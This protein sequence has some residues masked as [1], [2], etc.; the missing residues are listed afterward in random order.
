MY[1]LDGPITSHE[2]HSRCLKHL[3]AVNGEIELTT[4][5][6]GRATGCDAQGGPFVSLVDRQ[7]SRKVL[8]AKSKGSFD[9]CMWTCPGPG[10]AL[11][12]TKPTAWRRA[13]VGPRLYR[14][15]VDRQFGSKPRVDNVFREVMHGGKG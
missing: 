5:A 3:D 13:S 8:I 12:L 15:L 7:I 1:E 6:H 4:A 9:A 2:V 11:G 10:G 14:P